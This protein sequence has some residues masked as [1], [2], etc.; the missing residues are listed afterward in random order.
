MR[1][2]VKQ[3]SERLNKTRMTIWNY[4]ISGKLRFHQDFPRSNRYFYWNEVLED[5][6]IEIPYEKKITIGYCRVSTLDQK[7]DLEYQKQI[8]EQYCAKNGYNF[9]IIED[10]GSGINYNKKGL[11][12]LIELI[13]ENKINRIVLNHKDRLLRFGN[14]LVFEFCKLKNIDVEIIN[15]SEKENKEEELVKDVLQII[16]V[17]SSRLYGQRSH[18]NKQIVEQ[19]KILWNK[20]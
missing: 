19:N 17:F 2:K 16:T 9:K 12:E 11:K 8:V 14:E 3:I 18:K 5:L 15:Q 10:I 20:C 1:L 7:K 13:N 4:M 6:G